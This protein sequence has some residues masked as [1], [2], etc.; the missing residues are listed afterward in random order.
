MTDQFLFRF[1]QNIRSA[2]DIE[3]GLGEFMLL[4]EAFEK[5]YD[6]IDTEKVYDLCARLWLKSENQ[7]EAFRRLFEKEAIR[8]IQLLRK[9][10]QHIQLQQQRIE[11]KTPENKP[12][13]RKE[14]LENRDT[15]TQRSYAE[16]LEEAV[17]E[18]KKQAQY[19]TEEVKIQ[20]AQN[21][22]LIEQKDHKMAYTK[23]FL[24]S[25]NYHPISE[26]EM[27]QNLRFLRNKI[28]VGESQEVDMTATIE[29][30]AKKAVFENVVFQPKYENKLQLL[31]FIDIGS[32]MIAFH[33]LGKQLERSALKGGGQANTKVYFYRSAP[34]DY[35]FTQRD[36]TSFIKFADLFKGLNKPYTNAL[37]FSDAGAATTTEDADRT[38]LHWDFIEQLLPHLSHAAW[39]NPVP[40]S[41][42]IDTPAEMLSEM[43][44]MFEVNKIGFAKAIHVLRG[45]KG[46]E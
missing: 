2:L 38:I 5:G 17:K 34:E 42:W 10:L 7:E 33:H 16:R 18:E 6:P 35:V 36:G 31:I 1:F 37:F 26:R 12:P 23:Q 9:K 4:Q 41:R 13:E 45:K 30:V 11:K 46:I 22:Q 40:K 24:M 25:N 27:K 19:V 20:F 39:L 15:D 3:L 43:V 14:R 32:S 44:P 8:E 29:K 28:A 21:D